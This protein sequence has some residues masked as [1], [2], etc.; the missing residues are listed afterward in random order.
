[1]S[2]NTSFHTYKAWISLI[3]LNEMIFQ[4]VFYISINFH[5]NDVQPLIWWFAADLVKLLYLCH[6]SRDLN[7]LYLK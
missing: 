3:Y 5:G 4:V 1:M 6:L 2:E 7:V